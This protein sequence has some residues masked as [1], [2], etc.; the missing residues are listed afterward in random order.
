L[1]K[2]YFRIPEN[3]EKADAAVKLEAC[4]HEAPHSNCKL[5]FDFLSPFKFRNSMLKQATEYSFYILANPSSAGRRYVTYGL[6][7]CR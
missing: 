7:N 6:K 2:K 1:K 4:I 5:R 3:G